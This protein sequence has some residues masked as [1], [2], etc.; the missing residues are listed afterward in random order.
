MNTASGV[1]FRWRRIRNGRRVALSGGR[2]STDAEAEKEHRQNKVR[3]PCLYLEKKYTSC[4]PLERG[5]ND[6]GN[7]L[8]GNPGA[9]AVY[10]LWATWSYSLVRVAR[11]SVSPRGQRVFKYIVYLNKSFD[12]YVKSVCSCA[13]MY[14]CICVCTYM[15]DRGQPWVL[16]LRGCSLFSMEVFHY[17]GAEQVG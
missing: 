2:T 12:V 10:C 5:N 3:R 4:S 1:W 14:T 15:D 17:F 16:S 7:F 8:W 6:G 9:T 11:Y 13:C